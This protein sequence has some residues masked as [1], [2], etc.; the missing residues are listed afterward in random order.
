MDAGGGDEEVVGAGVF[1]DDA[2]DDDGGE[3]L[4]AA[5]TFEAGLDE[6]AVGVEDLNGGDGGFDDVGVIAADIPRRGAAVAGHAVAGSDGG[7]IADGEHGAVVDEDVDFA[8]DVSGDGDLGAGF[9]GLACCGDGERVSRCV[10]EEKVCKGKIGACF[11]R[12][13]DGG[14]HRGVAGGDGES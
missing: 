8:D 4:H 14:F 10:G 3:F 6:F 1:G 7:G 5:E 12:E 11:C 9:G 2:F 13:F